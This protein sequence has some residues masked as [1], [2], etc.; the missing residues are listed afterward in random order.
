MRSA[1]AVNRWWSKSAPLLLGVVLLFLATMIVLL[2][3]GQQRSTDKI[4]SLEYTSDSLSKALDDQRQAAKD[5][6]AEV[7]APPSDKIRKNPDLVEG[8]TGHDGAKGDT[9]ESGL[10]GEPGKDGK[11]GTPGSPGPTGPVGPPGPSGLAGP[12][13]VGVA[14]QNGTDG[15]AG[16]KGEKGD[17]GIQGPIGP[18]GET[19]AQGEPGKAPSKLT[20]TMLGVQYECTPIDG[21]TEYDCQPKATTP[22]PEP[23]NSPS[24]ATY[25]GGVSYYD[26]RWGLYV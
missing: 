1:R 16:A 23:T 17:P 21:T 8:V 2:Y 13:G 12:P 18:K 7:V 10:P 22:A 4:A 19:G 20:F 6:G 9:G 14:G 25:V 5:G 3:I 11:N 26:R 15:S 24:P